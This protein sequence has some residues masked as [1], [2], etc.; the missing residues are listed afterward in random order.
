METYCENCR[1]A[2]VVVKNRRLPLCPECRA[3]DK[4]ADYVVDEWLD[5]IQ[6]QEEKE[7]EPDGYYS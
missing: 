2:D 6:I 4:V 5:N 7:G 3:Q 1:H